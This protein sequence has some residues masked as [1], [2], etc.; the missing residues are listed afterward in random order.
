MMRSGRSYTDVEEQN[1]YADNLKGGVMD[2]VEKHTE[3]EN[4]IIRMKQTGGLS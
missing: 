2:E 3:G 1:S 4:P